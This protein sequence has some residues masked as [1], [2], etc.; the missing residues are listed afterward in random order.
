MST[1]Y[2]ASLPRRH[3]AHENVGI[4]SIC[5]AHPM[6]IEATLRHGLTSDG[7]VLIEAT[8]NQVNHEGGYT[9]MTPAD[10]RRFVEEIAAK[11]GFDT[12][13]LI[14]GGDHLGPNPWKSLPAEEA[15]GK[16]EA[17]VD[18]FVKAGFTKIHLD[19]S[20]GCAGESVA[21]ADEVTA[22]RAA[23]LAAVSEAAAK[24]SG[25]DLPVYVIGTEVP[26]P[27]GAME[28]IEELAV[29]DPE[30]AL[31]TVEVHRAAFAARGLEDAFARAIGVV[32]QPGVE[33]GNENIVFYDRAKAASLSAVLSKMPQFV[34]EA[35]STDYQPV[36]LLAGLVDDGFPILKVGPALTFAYREALY[37]L[38]QIAV[39]LDGLSPEET[40]KHAMEEVLVG[41][42]RE[43][44]KYYHGSDAEKRINRHFSYSD[45]IR[46]YWPQPKAVAAVTTLLT[47]LKGRQL[48]LPLISQYLGALYPAV[49]DGRLAATPESLILA[50]IDR[51]VSTYAAAAR[52]PAV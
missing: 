47:R 33:Y 51:V 48:P 30:A 31:A 45:R 44:A 23:R 50:N 21:L 26:I 1:A 39:E 4:S 27:G 8:C 6:V 24:E 17:M 15:M 36:E 2:L 52:T 43:W 3:Q 16:A 19:T 38:D 5:S 7:P 13:R 9:G 49:A 22:E 42:P 35:H 28:E 34:F 11:V 14:L 37:G 32:V 12:S 40:L 20:M 25:F 41:D 29:T 10:F 46:Y 18:A